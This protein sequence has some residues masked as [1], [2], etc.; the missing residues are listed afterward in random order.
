VDI[1]SIGK[2]AA[3]ALSRRKYDLVLMDYNMPEMDG[4]EAVRMIR[5]RGDMTP[6]VALSAHSGKEHRNN[7]SAVGV[8][9]Y[10]CKPFKQHQLF[11]LVDK[12]LKP[13]S[14]ENP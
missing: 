5:E 10:L 7:F 12:W 13:S 9:D 11:A 6:I 8:D 1:V 4:P 2:E 14:A 3:D